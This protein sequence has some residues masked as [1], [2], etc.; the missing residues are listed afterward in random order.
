VNA[1]PVPWVTPTDVSNVVAFLASDASRYMTGLLV[2][3][4]AGYLVKK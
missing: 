3:V 4:D 1:L 2:P